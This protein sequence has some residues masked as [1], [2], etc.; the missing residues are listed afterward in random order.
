M[1]RTWDSMQVV[2]VTDDNRLCS[3]ERESLEDTSSR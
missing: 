3:H 2:R 1:S